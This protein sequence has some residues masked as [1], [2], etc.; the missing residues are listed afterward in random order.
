MAF[1][2]L[3]DNIYKVK[4]LSFFWGGRERLTMCSSGQGL[5]LTLAMFQTKGANAEHDIVS[6]Q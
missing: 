6:W 5:F 4:N 1:Y 3:L 2:F